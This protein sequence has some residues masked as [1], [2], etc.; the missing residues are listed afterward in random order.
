SA[1]VS[2]SVRDRCG[3]GQAQPRSVGAG[4]ALLRARS[5]PAPVG[6]PAEEYHD[7]DTGAAHRGPEDKAQYTAAS[8]VVVLDRLQRGQSESDESNH[9]GDCCWRINWTAHSSSGSN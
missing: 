1:P 3:D 5:D 4:S 6:G 7:S 8:A 2:S 9:K